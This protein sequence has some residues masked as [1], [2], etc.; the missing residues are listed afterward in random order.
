MIADVRGARTSKRWRTILPVVVVG[1]VCGIFG[2][3]FLRHPIVGWPYGAAHKS[4][5]PPLWGVGLLAVPVVLLGVAV[6]KAWDRWAVEV[7]VRLSR[8]ARGRHP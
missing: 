6:W 7:Q 8:R 4:D 2:L 1:A 5:L 3:A